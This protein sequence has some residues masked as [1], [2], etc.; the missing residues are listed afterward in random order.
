MKLPVFDKKEDVPEAFRDGYVEREGKWHPD[1]EDVSGLRTSKQT[2]LDEKKKLED[3]VS[4]A[5]GGRKLEDVADLLAKQ[6]QAEDD[7]ARKKGDVDSIVAK[8]VKAIRDELEPKVKAG[9][10]AVAWRAEREFS[11]QISE[12]A[13]SDEIG[14]NPKKVRAV[15]KQL[16]DDYVIRGKDGKLVVIDAD[17]D[18]TGESIEKLLGGRFKKDFSEFYV[19]TGSSGGGSTGGNGVKKGQPGMLDAT[20]S[21]ALSSNID[22]IASGKVKVNVPE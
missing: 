22:D 4:K 14:V 19:G 15:I 6:T 21:A 5:L 12:V 16:R 1:V 20:D 7:L 11:D 9:E 13:L 2:A 18:P 3:A 17:G 8:Q 10:E